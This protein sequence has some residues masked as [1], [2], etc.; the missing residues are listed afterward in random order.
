MLESRPITV[1]ARYQTAQTAAVSP[2]P[3]AAGSVAVERPHHFSAQ[4]GWVIGALL[5]VQESVVSGIVTV[6]AF[7]GADP[8]VA[9]VVIL[10]GEHAIVAQVSRT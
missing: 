9:S 8:E 1:C 3:E 4:A 7:G 6:Q 2:Y 5:A 10:D